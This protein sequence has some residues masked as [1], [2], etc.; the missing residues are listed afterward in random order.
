MAHHVCPV[1]HKK[2][3]EMVLLSTRLKDE[4]ERENFMGYA[5]CP[6]HQEMASEFV[7]LVEMDGDPSSSEGASFTGQSAHVKWEV[8]DMVFGQQLDRRMPFVWVEVGVLDK[9]R[10][11][12]GQGSNGEGEVPH[13][14]H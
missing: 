10:A 5:L 12:S 14:V 2:H 3:G 8:A 1:C 4:L 11:M 9:L 7:A 13:G 6:E